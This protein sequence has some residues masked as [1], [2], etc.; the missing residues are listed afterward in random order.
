MKARGAAARGRHRR[1][2][3]RR[4]LTPAVAAVRVSS[5]DSSTCKTPRSTPS[6][7]GTWRLSPAGAPQSR[8]P[9]GN[10]DLEPEKGRTGCENTLSRGPRVQLHALPSPFPSTCRPHFPSASQAHRLPPPLREVQAVAKRG[11]RKGYVYSIPQN[12]LSRCRVFCIKNQHPKIH[13]MGFFKC[14]KISSLAV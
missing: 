4:L 1:P 6:T 2:A 14:R 8:V 13:E 9:P 10:S 3:R 12:V 11:Q 7:G 5:G